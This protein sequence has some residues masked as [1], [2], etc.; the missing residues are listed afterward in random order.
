MATLVAGDTLSLGNLGAA[1]DQGGTNISLGTIKGSPILGDNIGL[2]EFA[3]DS[4]DSVEGFTYVVENTTEQYNLTVSGE[5]NYFLSTIATFSS[6]FSWSVDGSYMSFDVLDN[7]GISASFDALDMNPQDPSAQTTLLTSQSHQVCCKFEDGFNDHIGA[8]NNYGV[9]VCKTVWTLDSYDG[10][11]SGLCLTTDSPIIL[12]DGSII[13]AGDLE[14]GMKLKGYQLEG[15]SE[16]S[17]LDFY[18]W[19]T[20]NL[21]ETE[22]IVTVVNVTF[23]FADKYYSLN[24]GEVTATFEHPLLVIDSVDD[25]Y[26]F[27]PIGSIV[28]GDYLLKHTDGGLIEIEVTSNDI[29]YET[30]EIVSIDVEKQD[31][32]LVNGYVTHNKGTN[33][34]I[35]ELSAPAAPSSF[36]YSSPNLSWVAPASE[37]DTGITAYD[38]QVDS[39][40]GDFSSPIIDET[41]WSSTSIEVDSLLVSSTA[42][43]ARVRAI[44][45]GLKGD[46]AILD[47]TTA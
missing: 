29:I 41:E 23:S 20:D 27:K 21:I 10:N 12:E 9:N 25:M 18:K 36:T 24:N 5:G 2:S 45:Q 13:E 4:V 30:I 43:D 33:S 1:T 38:I 44:D 32:Y 6:S 31:T 19:N 15:L 34:G 28:K 22:K 39:N 11:T 3:I 14:D 47:F 46:W 8:G 26:K 35:I 7:N 40:G 17:D 16:D 42:Y 37:G